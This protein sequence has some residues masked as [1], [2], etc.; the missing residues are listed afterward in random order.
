M[1][2]SVWTR[3][4]LALSVALCLSLPIGAAAAAKKPAGNVT[5]ASLVKRPPAPA[6]KDY[7]KPV[8]AKKVARSKGAA[9]ERDWTVLYYL[10]ADCNL[11]PDMLDDVDEMEMIGSTDNVNLLA[12]LDR[13]P[14]YDDRDGNW[15]N[16]RLY[17]I[18]HDTQKGKLASKLLEN[19]KE[20]DTANPGTLAD[21]IAFGMQ[22][23]PA[24]HYALVL[25]N[26]GGTWMG[27][28]NDETDN[29]GGMKLAPFI[30]SLAALKSA[31]APAF[32]VITFDMCL[33]AQV[34]VMDAI[35]PYAA[36][37]V[38]SEETEPGTGYPNTRVL[39]AL[40]KN[41]KMSPRDFAQTMVREW[42]A[43]YSEAGEATVTSSATD[44]AKVKDVVAA[45]DS[46]ATALVQAPG[47][48][49][50][51]AAR[52]RAATH[53]YGGQDNGGAL[54]SYDLGEF[55]S[56]L[57]Q[58]SE[59][60]ALKPQ[61]DAVRSAVQSAV[62]EHA[63]GEAHKG[64]T[65]LAIYFPVDQKVD[66][67]YASLPFV[68]GKWD[69]FLAKGLTAAG[70]GAMAVKI[71]APDPAATHPIGSGL[72]VTATVSGN[73]TAVRAAIGY[74]DA[75][76]GITTVSDE[77]IPS[78]GAKPNADGSL[79]CA[80]KDGDTF[81]YQ[82]DAKV[83]AI[84]DGKGA[85]LAPTTP[86]T[87][88]S[89]F[90]RADAS[91]NSMRGD[92]Q[93]SAIFD[94]KSGKL[95]TIF[96]QNEKGAR[97]PMAVHPVAGEK[98]VFYQPATGG[99]GSG[100]EGAR[101]RPVPALVSSGHGRAA[102]KPGRADAHDTGLKLVESG[103]PAG[104][105]VLRLIAYDAAG[106]P[107][108]AS[109][110]QLT[111]SGEGVAPGVDYPDYGLPAVAADD[112]QYVDLT[113]IIPPAEYGHF[114]ATWS[115]YDFMFE[116][117]SDDFTTQDLAYLSDVALDA[118]ELHFDRDEWSD[119]FAEELSPPDADLD[120]DGTPDEEDAD[121]DNDGTPDDQDA[122]DDNDG[123][124]DAED[125]DDDN[126]GI[127]DAEASDED[128]DGIPDDQDTDDDNDG[129]PDEQ[130]TDDDNDGIDDADDPDD[131]ND[132]VPDVDDDTGDDPGDEGGDEGGD[133]DGG[134]D[135]GDDD[136]GDDD[137]L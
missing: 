31:G 78:P 33:M 7:A 41:P 127:P 42:D 46:L 43:S 69:E 66:P 10:D 133:D 89:R 76:G 101:F 86:L 22:N 12:L 73:P 107:S 64:S 32:D 112:V 115:D 123:I 98:L 52:A 118:E 91:Y 56:L 54:T 67:N 81:T 61:L 45:V 125:D 25:G 59:A 1:F 30:Q 80:W 134:D 57:S 3:L 2:R 85:R 65:G 97:T 6:A 29:A 26:H 88:G 40:T 106:N 132:G 5:S 11:E 19:L 121:D 28:L 35:S 131:D 39:Q 87:P 8:V 137:G 68:R 70:G 34:E 72:Q 130:D 136:G 9:A 114:D 128:D 108:E 110:L 92:M 96:C 124:P 63:E 99:K 122:D 47:P 77:E 55:V 119:E 4:V 116:F 102:G 74:R 36:Y 79:V 15:P 58:Q 14:G 82:V 100:K 113:Q 17:Y 51:A 105:Y 60:S 71:S 16:S 109:D 48:A 90:V 126:D 84:S 44:L 104:D 49:Q 94:T 38:A 53:F 83:R 117:Q 75:D 93:V 62:V 135:G 120:G 23:F 111:A 13:S 50:A 37:G 21:F 129:T 103:L 20:M 95:E 27:M 18:T 24:K